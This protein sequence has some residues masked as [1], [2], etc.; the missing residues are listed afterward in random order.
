MSRS[1]PVNN[2]IRGFDAARIPLCSFIT[3]T[4]AGQ[5]VCFVGSDDRALAMNIAHYL[6]VKLSGRGEIVIIEG[7]A[8]SATSRDRLNGFHD[9]LVAYPNIKV[10]LS[11]CGE[12][13]RDVSRHAF[14]NV[15][16]SKRDHPSGASYRCHQYFQMELAA[17]SALMPKLAGR[18]SSFDIE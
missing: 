10:R 6:F 14:L 9:A 8:A 12:Y 1:W 4:T 15:I 2:A 13:Q 18:H 11:L 5:R 3:R 7:T 16:Q 17:R